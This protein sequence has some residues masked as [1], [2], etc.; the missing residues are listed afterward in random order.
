MKGVWLVFKKEILEFTK[1]RKTMF[2]TLAV[3]IILYP[4]LFGMIGK[5][6]QRED[7]QARS[8]Q[9]RIALIDPSNVIESLI[10]ARTNDFTLVPAPEDDEKARQAIKDDQL[11]ML[12]TLG[13]S[14]AQDMAEQKTVAVDVLYNR[15]EKTGRVAMKRL[16]DALRELNNAT[17]Q[18]RLQKLGASSQLAAPTSIQSR[19]VGGEE[20]LLAKLLGTMLP[21]MLMLMLFVGSMQLGIYVT[22]GE[23]ER[24]TL[25][26]LLATGLPRHEIIWGKLLY[27]FFMGIVNSVI[28]IGAM[29]FSMGTLFGGREVSDGYAAVAAEEAA[30]LSGIAAVVD[31]TV[32]TLTLLL[33]IPLGLLFSNLI[34]FLG[35]QAKN[36]QEAGTSMMPVVLL[37]LFLGVFSMAPGIEKMGILPYIPIVNV[38][39]V[40]RK[41][42][43]QQASVM[44]Y[45]TAFCMTVGLAVLLTYI[46][47]KFL[48]RESAI[49]KST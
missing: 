9:T 18:D 6:G 10:Q 41:L 43:A 22:A 5:M 14:A 28:N 27:V 48:N 42:F 45:L 38:S 32:I 12:V 7:Q 4:L 36:T 16:E 2:F 11:E 44:E 46:S 13:A 23:R 31:P 8:S 3:P 19:Q 25:I 49:F 15:V 26:T 34:V 17:V 37:V 40:I 35:V 33:M 29:T 1:D 30:Q 20:L 39:L 24:G 21:Y 47:T